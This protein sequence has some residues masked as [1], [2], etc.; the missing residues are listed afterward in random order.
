MKVPLLQIPLS[1][2]VAIKSRGKAGSHQM[3]TFAFASLALV[4]ILLVPVGTISKT[5]FE[6][7][8]AEIRTFE[9]IRLGD[10]PADARDDRGMSQYNFAVLF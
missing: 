6:R 5:A 2:A 3:D 7:H 9:T 10:I 1:D 4:R 8:A